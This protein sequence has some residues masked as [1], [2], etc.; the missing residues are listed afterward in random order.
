[1][2]QESYDNIENHNLDGNITEFQSLNPA[3]GAIIWRGKQAS[4]EDVGF[5]INRSRQAFLSWSRMRFDE[6]LSLLSR[7]TEILEQETETFAQYISDEVG[8]PRWEALLEVKAMVGKLAISVE[9][10]QD[11]CRN[12]EKKVGEKHSITRHKPHGVLAVIGPFNFPGHLPNGHIIPALLAGNTVILKPSDKTPFVGEKLVDLFSRA[13]MPQNVVSLV[14][15]GVN[16][17]MSLV[18]HPD[19]DGVLFTGSSVVGQALSRLLART[20]HKILAC[21]MGGNN[22]LI[23]SHCED[24]VAAAYT[25]VQSAYIT[26]GQR[27]TCARRLIVVENEKSNKYLDVLCDMIQSIKVGSP[28]MTPEPFMG[29]VISNNV[30]ESLLS[31][32]SFLKR[33]GAKELV[34]MQ[35]LESNLPFLSPGL[36]DISLLNNYE[37]QECFGPLLQLIKV[38]D[39]ETAFNVANKTQF[40][41]SAGIL[42][43]N[44][45]DYDDFYRVSRAGLVNWNTSTTGASSAAPFGGL[46]K[47]GN[48]RPS[49]YYAA[50]YCSYPV[51]SME[52]E[53]VSMPISLSPG[54]S[55]GKFW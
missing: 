29:P 5:A 3:T 40:G 53:K 45:Q 18:A 2:V 38:S 17:S 41:L 15:G 47:S 26:S 36:L 30:A 43:D 22:P 13:G 16:P 51:A 9:A 31:Y 25:T 1:M 55:G 12:I 35:R 32:Y 39:L 27:C 10:Y 52:S 46:G 14:Q 11:R 49:A 4:S 33:R 34:T 54:I 48:H 19:I 37:D 8:K 28:T 44:K 6:R 23:V 7:Y 21:E 42:S 24:V 20:P 50:D